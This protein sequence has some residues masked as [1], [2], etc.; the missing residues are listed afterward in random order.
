M[1]EESRA[2]ACTTHAWKPCAIPRAALLG[3][4]G[5]HPHVAAPLGDSRASGTPNN[6]LSLNSQCS[7]NSSRFLLSSGQKATCLLQE[8]LPAQVC[9]SIYICK[10]EDSHCLSISLLCLSRHCFTLM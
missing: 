8:H 9:N 3:D 5:M 4:T 6:G 7:R 10:T 2:H 1:G